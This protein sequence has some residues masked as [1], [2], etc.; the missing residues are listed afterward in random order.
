MTKAGSRNTTLFTSVFLIISLLYLSSCK[1]DAIID[2]DPSVK[3]GFSTD[4]VI[5]DTVFTTL[6]SVTRH[7]KVYNPSGNTIRISSIRL[8]GGSQ[9][10]YRLNIDGEAAFAIKDVELAG[11]DSLYIFVRVTIDPTDENNP[12]VVTDS[13]L[14]ETNGNIQDVDL[15]AWGQNANY[16][17][18]D[19]QVPGFPKYKIIAHEFE[20][21]TWTADK[22]Y[23]IYGFA[24]VDSNGTLRVNAGARIY[25]HDKSGMWIY[26]GGT[27]KVN[28][29][30][31]EPVTFQGDRLEDFYKDLPGQWDRIWINEGSFNNEI[32]YAVI[33]NGFIGI[34]AET[35]Q[36]QM[37]NQLILTN[38]IIENMSGYGLLSRFYNIT[39]NNNVIANCGQYLA[40]LTWGGLYDFRNCTFANY[41][42]LSVRPT[43]SL[44]LNNYFEDNMGQVT[45]FEFDSYFGNCIIYG[46]NEEEM[47]YLFNDEAPY[48]YFFDNCLFKTELEIDDIQHY[49]NCFKNEDP[50]FIDY[51]INDYQLDTLSPAIDRGDPEVI[52]TSPID[53]SLDILQVPRMPDPDLGAYEFVPGSRMPSF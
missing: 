51:T 23:V 1:K 40:A 10:P 38:T 11:N 45:A 46:R 15:A 13:I 6:G 37:G 12:F 41:W 4:T 14:F 47:L 9:S 31:E 30:F 20:D 8:A 28:G 22:P 36:E 29:T 33:R 17:L 27:I 44:V 7:L 5:F 2:T 50:L 19:T 3:L 49:D 21:I 24:V 25:F 48:D 35:L 16:I 34:Q 18:A 39:A 42:P 52:N 32:N 43:P 26:K 53:I